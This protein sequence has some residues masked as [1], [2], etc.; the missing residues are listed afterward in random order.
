M[1]P[2]GY[3]VTENYDDPEMYGL[4]DPSGFIRDIDEYEKG[5]ADAEGDGK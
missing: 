1:L 3:R 2:V 4:D 5:K